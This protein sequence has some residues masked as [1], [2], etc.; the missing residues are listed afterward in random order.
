MGMFLTDEQSR[1]KLQGGEAE[2]PSTKFV[3]DQVH[4]VLDVL[5]VLCTVESATAK[6][7]GA[8]HAHSG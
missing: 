4:T 1:P 6:E 7:N 5:K 2:D 8:D 3:L